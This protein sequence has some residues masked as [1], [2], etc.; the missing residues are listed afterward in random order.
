MFI[1]N[2]QQR[3]SLSIYPITQIS[4]DTGLSRYKIENITSLDN[5]ETIADYLTAESNHR[6]NIKES[7]Q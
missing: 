5:A 1:H 4:R 6:K 7:K 2:T 3:V